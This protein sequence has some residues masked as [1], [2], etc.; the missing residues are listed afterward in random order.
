MMALGLNKRGHVGTKHLSREGTTHVNVG[1]ICLCGG[2]LGDVA[3]WWPR[4]AF[5]QSVGL[6][7]MRRSQPDAGVF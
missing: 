6:S 2:L 7:I 4:A 1:N 5:I 3:G